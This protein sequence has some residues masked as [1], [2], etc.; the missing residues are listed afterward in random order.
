MWALSGSVL[1]TTKNISSRICACSM[2]MWKVLT[3][4]KSHG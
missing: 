3:G 4:V 1:T 2:R